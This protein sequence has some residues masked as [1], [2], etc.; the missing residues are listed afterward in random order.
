MLTGQL[1]KGVTSF[2]PI[3]SYDAPVEPE[4]DQ[5]WFD[6]NEKKMKIWMNGWRQVLRV[7]AGT[8]KG[9]VLTC[10]PLGSQ[11]GLSEEVDAGYIIYGVDFLPLRD[12]T[13]KFA[14]SSNEIRFNIAGFTQPL[15]I[16]TMTLWGTA[17]ESLPAYSFVSR[18]IDGGCYLADQ[19]T[20]FAIR[21]H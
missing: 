9:G 4:V 16:D 1:S 18:D 10:Y 3:T 15:S 8:I 2:R 5:H 12:S 6:L 17:N 19:D 7:F 11:V 13:G 20:S 21:Y 14:S